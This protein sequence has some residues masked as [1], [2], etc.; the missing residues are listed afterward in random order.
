MGATNSILGTARLPTSKGTLQGRSETDPISKK[1][2][3]TRYTRVPYALPPTGA[4]RWQKPVPLPAEF[5]FTS[6]DG[7]AGDYTEF[8]NVCPQPIYKHGSVVLPNDKA[9]PPHVRNYSEDC[10]Y[11][12]IWVPAGEVPEGGWPVQAYIHGGWLQVGDAMQSNEHDPYHLIK[13]FPRIIVAVSYRLNVFGFLSS[14]ALEAANFGFWDQRLAL[15]WTF[16]NIS[17]FGGNPENISLGGLSA[18]AYSTIFQL[19]YDTYLPEEKRIIKRVFLYSNA[20]GVQPDPISSSASEE[21]FEDLCSRFSISSKL[22]DTDKI[23]ALREVP[24]TKLADEILSLKKH[25]FRAGTDSEFISGSFLKSIYD[26][27]FTS[28]LK[29]H[30]ISIMLGEVAN[31][32]MLYRLVNPASSYETLISELNNYYPATMTEGL[33]NSGIYDIPARNEPSK[34]KWRDCFAGI[35]ADCQVHATVRGFASTLL[36]GSD[37]LP[38]E[39]VFR[40][41]ICWRAKGLDEWLDPSVGLCHAADVPIWT[42]SGTRAGYDDVDVGRVKEWLKPQMQFLEGKKVEW[43]T[44]SLREVRRF[45][46]NGDIEIVGDDLWHRGLE[47]WNCIGKAQL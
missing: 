10:L 18:G 33:L 20:V 30:N 1:L 17:L 11:L 4:R 23:K 37:P 45:S 28:L 43:G 44:T 5:S 46:S 19:H 36:D 39:N 42:L 12:N 3:C 47:V 2:V 16:E 41:R 40:Y 8:G 38:L 22:S 35:V 26:G 25:T 15:E 24:D 9:A 13:D 27:S 6:E 7:N 21:Q 29:K 14:P 32:E 34:D 31:E